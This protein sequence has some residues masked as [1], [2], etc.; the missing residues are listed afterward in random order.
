MAVNEEVFEQWRRD[1]ARLLRLLMR[2]ALCNETA[3]NVLISELSRLKETDGSEIRQ[4]IDALTERFKL[5]EN[6]YEEADLS[7]LL[8]QLLEDYEGDG[9]LH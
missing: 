3:T 4:K 9:T 8:R 7:E 2:Q 6:S 1:I 5:P